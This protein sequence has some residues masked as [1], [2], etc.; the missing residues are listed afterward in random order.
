MDHARRFHFHGHALGVAAR[1]RRPED[2]SWPVQACSSLPVTGGEHQSEIGP[3]ELGKWVSFQSAATSMRGDYTD[4]AAAV[5]MTLG[6]VAFD[7][8][9]VETVVKSSVRGLSVLGRLFV[10]VAEMGLTSRSSQK[11]GQPSIQVNGARLEDVRVDNSRLKI[12]LGEQ[13]FRD[14]DTKEKLATGFAKDL[15]KGHGH[16]F[17]RPGSQSAAPERLPEAGGVVKCTLVQEM[18]WADAPHPTATIDGHALIIPNFGKVF[19]GEM[20]ITENSRR[21]TMV[22]CQLGSDDGG[23]VSAAEGEANGHTWPP[24]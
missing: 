12:T 15:P 24:G 18:A 8:V 13:L 10:G 2:R 22:R 5:A 7:A 14:H 20:V 19:F 16:M 21:L 1:I 4:R 6:E 9:P 17:L 11:P 23:E 3:T